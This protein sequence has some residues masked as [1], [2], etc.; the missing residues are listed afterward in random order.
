MLKR[1]RLYLPAITAI[2][3]LTACQG[4]S[5]EELDGSQP[6]SGKTRV[7]LRIAT[8]NAISDKASTRAWED[9][10]AKTDRTEMMYS[11]YVLLVDASNKVVYK[12]SSTTVAEANAEIDIVAENLELT[13]G[14]YTA[15]SFANI[16]EGSLPDA[17]KKAVGA[18]FT[19]SDVTALANATYTVN[20]NGF[21]PSSNQG[22]P[23]SNKQTLTIAASDTEKDLIVIRMLAKMEVSF[24]NKTGAEATVQSFTISDIT[25]NADNNLKLLPSLT[26]GA[27]TMDAVHGDIQPN[28]N[29]SATASDY[30]VVVNKTIANNAKETVTFYINE[31]ATPSNADGLFYLTVKMNNTDYRYA[32]I[33]QIG[34]TSADN[35][36]WHY[37]ARNDYRILPIVLDEYKLEL[38]PYDFPPIGVY[39]VSVREIESDLYEMTF[40]DYGH[41][42]LVPKVT[43]T[44]NSTIVDYSSDTTPTGTAWTLNTDFAGSWKTA[45][46]KGGDWLDA[47]GVTSNGFYRNETATVDGDE[48]GG[49]PVWYA[50]TSSPQWDPAG[51]TNY[52]PFIFGYIADPGTSLSEDKKIY[53]EFRVKLYVGGVYR[54]DLLYRFYMKLPAGQMMLTRQFSRSPFPS[55]S[56]HP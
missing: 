3:A 13:A 17:I 45:A 52:A 40:H 28:L 16:P 20:G 18:E 21:T 5:V 31:S 54:R 51:G 10:N 56:K 19:S 22:I 50:N 7:T 35:D 39:P 25:T 48:V 37:I 47:A 42:H 46:T 6:S 34:K 8:D 14:T 53:H 4:D 38:I 2:F 33:N 55:A 44:S 15:Y 29:T 27:N 30:T 24:E 32:L 36:A 49:A 1:L 41:F 12:N 9:A 26:S 23:M 11:W 43:N